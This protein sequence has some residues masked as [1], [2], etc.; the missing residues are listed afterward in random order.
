[1]TKKPASLLLLSAI[2]LAPFLASTAQAG[3]RRIRPVGPPVV[4]LIAKKPVSPS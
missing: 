1:M 3:T 4:I 2:A